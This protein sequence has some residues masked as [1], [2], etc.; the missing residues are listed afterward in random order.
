MLSPIREWKKVFAKDLSYIS[1]ELRALIA[2]PA[3]V[4][5]SGPVGV[6]KTTFTKFFVKNY[7]TKN[8]LNG[9]T[10]SQEQQVSSPTYSLVNDYGETVHADF[11]RL[12]GPQEILQLELGLYLEDTDYFL[13]EWG[14]NFQKE[15]EKEIP[16]DFTFYELEIKMHNVGPARNFFL[17][18]L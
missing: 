17:N 16:D 14:K 6:G 10:E 9:P 1:E 12:Q 7:S 15:I 11:Y 18:K 2:V 4:I 5:L 8:F 3:V 13:V